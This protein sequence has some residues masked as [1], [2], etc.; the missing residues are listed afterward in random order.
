MAQNISPDRSQSSNLAKQNDEAVTIKDNH[1]VSKR[2]VS[3]TYYFSFFFFTF[4]IIAQYKTKSTKMLGDHFDVSKLIY[5][6]N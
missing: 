2:F 3:S 4:E 6:V 1:A 5:R